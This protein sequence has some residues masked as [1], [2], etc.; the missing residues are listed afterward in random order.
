MPICQFYSWVLET[1]TILY[2][3]KMSFQF[4]APLILLLASVGAYIGRGLV[5]DVMLMFLAGIIG[6]CWAVCLFY[7]NC[8]WYHS[9]QDWRAKLCS[10]HADGAL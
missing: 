5:L 8:S 2:L 1:K 7:L 3:L 9:G 10:R 4:L 6:F